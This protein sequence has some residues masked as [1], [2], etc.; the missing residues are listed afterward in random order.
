MPPGEPN[1]RC[2]RELFTQPEQWAETRSLVTVL[3][4]TAN[5]LTKNFT[6]DELRVW[7]PQIEK[8]GI[9]L[10][11]EVGAV[12]EWGTT[13]QK[14]FDVQRREWDRLQ[15]LGG[16]ITA[17][18]MDEPLCCV[19]KSL[20]KDD[21][22]AVEETANFIALVRKNYPDIRIGDIEPYPFFQREEL[23]SFIDALEAKLKQ[24][25]VRGLDFFRLDV[26]WNHFTNGNRLYPGNWPD[27]K[28]LELACRQRKLPFSLIYWAA[29]YGRM[30]QLNL[31]D[32]STWYVGVM[33]QGYDYTTVGG[34]PD[35]YV[36][37][38]WVG[39]PSKAVPE[40]TDWTFAR[41][42]HDFCQRFVK[43]K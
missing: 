37:E 43:P 30:K 23:V 29:D 28:K 31:A 20:K 8:W 39:A 33:R 36:I 16:K 35:E 34:A 21:A 42:V 6:D 1:A 2:L 3:G 9:K 41:S 40:T 12:K 4:C 7:L 26:D 22:Y 17:I 18:A 38:S 27:V 10:G 25:G 24:M 32:D 13:G 19:R 5:Q 11:L 15:S 14:V